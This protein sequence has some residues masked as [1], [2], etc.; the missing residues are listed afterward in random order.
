MA[1]PSP[2]IGERIV[3]NSLKQ[4]K[5]VEFVAHLIAA[6]DEYEKYF[7]DLSAE[8][9]SPLEKLTDTMEP[10][11]EIF[12]R[13]VIYAGPMNTFLS[14]FITGV[15]WGILYAKREK[16]LDELSKLRNAILR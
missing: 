13:M 5:F 12:I 3:D 10:V 6:Q 15:Q 9:G 11:L 7:V 2:K 1:I 4:E 14:C 8:F 16:D